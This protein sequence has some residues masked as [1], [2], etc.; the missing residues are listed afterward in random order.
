LL[1]LLRVLPLL[2]LVPFVPIKLGSAFMPP[3]CCALSRP[4][5]HPLP[6]LVLT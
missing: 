1:W 6:F 5:S 3:P 2:L 4:P